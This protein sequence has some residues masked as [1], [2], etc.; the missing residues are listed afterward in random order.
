MSRILGILQG[1]LIVSCQPVPGGPMDQPQTVAAFALAAL[2]GGAVGLRVEG[3]ANLR[4][5]RAVT[6]APIIGL[7][8]RDL[9]ESPVR[10][11]PYLSDVAD[12]AAAGA[13]VIA[14]DATRRARPVPCDAI[15]RAIHA[16]GCLAMADCSDLEDGMA[17][18]AA[19]ADILGSTMS[20]YTGGSVPEVPDLGIV[21]SMAR[22]GAFV[23]A[24]GR[25]HVPQQ[26]ADAIRHG[27]R[28][29]VVGSAI[30]RTEH[31]TEWFAAAIRAAQQATQDAKPVLSV[32]LG[33]SK[34]LAALVQGD[35][36]LARSETATDRTAGPEVWLEQVLGLSSDWKGAFD[37]AGIAVTGLAAQGLW[38][39]LN[40]AT[41]DIPVDYALQSRAETLLAT[42][43]MIANDAQAAAWGEFVFGAGA[44]SDMIFL[45]ISTGIGGGVVA[46]GRLL[47]GRNGLAGHFGQIA[48]G[49]V[50]ADGLRLE[51]RASGRWIAAEGAR[52]GLAADARAVFTA[53]T[54]GDARAADIVATS[55]SR[56]AHLCADLQFMFDP[57]RIVIGGGV[58]LAP[59]YLDRIR[60]ALAPLDPIRRPDLVAARLGRDAGIVGMA[61]LARMDQN[62]REKRQ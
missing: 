51:D 48:A 27:A 56:V 17:A 39:A 29:V 4:A 10:I 62:N 46:G 2:A 58:G 9:A 7:V 41:L 16:A 31:V 54:A 44:H 23:V 19:G 50:S 5:V 59:G 20:G 30:T 3:I 57:D 52:T 38:R 53:A 13:D 47:R 24:E 6:T 37:R 8:K 11:T 28:A 42:P 35:R 22:T 36:I 21:D 26:A 12:L 14:F 60:Q 15:I 40:P 34:I 32:D 18:H 49:E 33:G 43:V 55:A 61:D 45:T 25:Y 1:G